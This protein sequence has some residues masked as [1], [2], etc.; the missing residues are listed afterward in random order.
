MNN[1][2]EVWLAGGRFVARRPTILGRPNLRS[3]ETTFF[4]SLV[5]GAL[6]SASRFKERTSFKAP[7]LFHG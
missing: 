5:S 1:A 3:Q 7:F 2:P 4:N 6:R